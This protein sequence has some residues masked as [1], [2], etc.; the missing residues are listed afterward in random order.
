[1]RKTP[2][3]EPKAQ[4]QRRDILR[5][6]G[7]SFTFDEE[8]VLAKANQNL[9][10]TKS[11]MTLKNMPKFDALKRYGVSDDVEQQPWKLEIK[12]LIA[13]SKSEEEEKTSCLTARR[14][15]AVLVLKA[16]LIYRVWQTR[17]FAI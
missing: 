15:W 12:R 14:F 8:S 11:G 13:T 7:H 2:E 17:S 16:T 4:P 3:P 10:Y 6:A 5:R 1:M 9:S